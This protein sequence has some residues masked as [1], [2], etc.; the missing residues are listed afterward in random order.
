MRDPIKSRFDNLLFGLFTRSWDAARIASW[1]RNET[2]VKTA[3]GISSDAFQMIDVKA[4]GMLTHVSMMIAGL[5]ISAP[6]LAQHPV[7]EAVIVGEICVYLL[8]A[9]GCLRCLSVLN[10][11]DIP[12]KPAEIKKRV[13][14]E[15]IIRQ[16]LYR[17]C[18]RFTI[19]F[20]VLV[21]IS[22]P[23]MLWWKPMKLVAP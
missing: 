11:S 6:L 19:R 4:A 8:I 2:H 12:G 14:R 10:T 3:D 16:E 7:E 20:T 21:F 22:L 13:Q 17:F 18:N 1:P 9:V 5:G 15:L 23:I